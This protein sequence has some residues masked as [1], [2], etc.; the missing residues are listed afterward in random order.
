[1][2]L[3]QCIS[4]LR[5]AHISIAL[6]GVAA[7][8]ELLLALIDGHAVSGRAPQPAIEPTKMVDI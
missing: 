4:N 7:D 3:A 8:P 2:R 1:M 6:S 5:A